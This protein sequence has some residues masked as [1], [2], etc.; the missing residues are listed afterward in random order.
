M[1]DASY[2]E[3]KQNEARRDARRKYACMLE[4]P[5]VN[6]PL[7]CVMFLGRLNEAIDTLSA[8]QDDYYTDYIWN[9]GSAQKKQLDENGFTET[10]FSEVEDKLSLLRNILMGDNYNWSEA[11]DSMY[12]VALGHEVYWREFYKKRAENVEAKLRKIERERG[13][14]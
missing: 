2:I 6:E 3:E 11:Y 13:K 7:E 4:L 10:W 9:S 1:S 5:T 8:L 12:K 14:T